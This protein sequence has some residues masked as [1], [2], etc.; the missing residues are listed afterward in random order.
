[1]IA[2]HVTRSIALLLRI[3]VLIIANILPIKYRGIKIVVAGF[4]IVKLKTALPITNA[5]VSA[6]SQ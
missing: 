1:M 2:N 3:Y 4:K 6:T 5:T